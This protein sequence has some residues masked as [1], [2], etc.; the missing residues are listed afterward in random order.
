MEERIRKMDEGAD[1]VDLCTFAT[2]CKDNKPHQWL[3]SAISLASRRNPITVATDA[4]NGDGCPAV[5][6]RLDLLGV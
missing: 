5:R 1:V 2:S 4:S 3:L 6:N